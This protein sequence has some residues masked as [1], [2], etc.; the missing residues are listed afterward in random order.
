MLF[1]VHQV[2]ATIIRF[3]D[4]GN[5]TRPGQLGALSPTRRVYSYNTVCDYN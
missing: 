5:L 3:K 4:G 2:A 1:F